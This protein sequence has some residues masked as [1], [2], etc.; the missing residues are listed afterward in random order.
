M[1]FSIVGVRAHLANA[2]RDVAS[3]RAAGLGGAVVRWGPVTSARVGW[4]LLAIGTLILAVVAAERSVVLLV[5]VLAGF[6]GARL[7]AARS[8]SR[9]AMFRGL[10]IA[11]AVDVVAVLIAAS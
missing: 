3:D 10:L 6:L 11:V 1:V 7:Y 8:G 4:A 2:L 5:L 9:D